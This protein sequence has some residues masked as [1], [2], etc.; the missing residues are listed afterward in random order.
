MLVKRVEISASVPYPLRG[1]IQAIGG[2]GGITS[3]ANLK[4]VTNSFPNAK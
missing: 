2:S 4:L 3:A 1:A